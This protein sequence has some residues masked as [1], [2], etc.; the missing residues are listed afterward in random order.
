MKR[1]STLLAFVA[2][3]AFAIPAFAAG[4]APTGQTLFPFQGDQSYPANTAFNIRGGFSELRGTHAWG[5][6]EYKLTLDG[7][8]VKPSYMT[9]VQTDD[10]AIIR[11]WWYNFPE[12]M[13]GVHDFVATYS[14]PCEDGSLVECNGLRANSLVEVGQFPMQVTFTP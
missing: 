7:A 9:N 13:T 14:A 12:G 2:L 6:F 4:P 8:T 11:L 3:L 1:R 5:K 10:G